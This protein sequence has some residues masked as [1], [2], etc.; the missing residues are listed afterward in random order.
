MYP[1]IDELEVM[2]EG[3]HSAPLAPDASSPH[4]E[5]EAGSGTGQALAGEIGYRVMKVDSLPD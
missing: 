3:L 5:I 1:L 4:G 2:F